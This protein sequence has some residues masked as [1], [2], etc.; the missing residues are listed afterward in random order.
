MITQDEAQIDE[1]LEDWVEVAKAE[2][3][4][5]RQARDNNRRGREDGEARVSA[6]E[7]DA[8]RQQQQRDQEQDLAYARSMDLQT[9]IR[10]RY[11]IKN[12][13][14]NAVLKEALKEHLWA[15]KGQWI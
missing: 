12:A 6:V 9:F 7:N 5:R 3:E 11:E 8:E 14:E 10:K 4:A 2:D 15:L 13:S 1:E